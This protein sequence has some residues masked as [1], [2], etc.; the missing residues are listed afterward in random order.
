MFGKE[1]VGLFSLNVTACHAPDQVAGVVIPMGSGPVRTCSR[2]ER[3]AR[4]KAR[5]ED[6][7]RLVEYARDAVGPLKEENQ[8]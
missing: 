4:W 5:Q 2:A 3:T 8:R 6:C 7:L 1:K